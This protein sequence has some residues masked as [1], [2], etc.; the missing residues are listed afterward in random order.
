MA[1]TVKI[2]LQ[3]GP[4]DGQ[5]ATVQR[6]GDLLPGFTCKGTD[7]QPTETVNA[8]GRVVYTTKQSQ[9]APPPAA[10]PNKA[11]SSWHQMLVNMFVDVPKELHGSRRAREAIGGLR[12]HRGLK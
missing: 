9:Q 7:Y 4:C 5:N 3:G 10:T 6:S 2:H 11:H 8:A 12:R 1:T